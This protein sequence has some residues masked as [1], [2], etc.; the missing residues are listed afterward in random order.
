MN[1]ILTTA[2]ALVLAL[3]LAACE[4][5]APE[6]TTPPESTETAP[7]EPEKGDA[8]ACSE[9]Y[10]E[11][12]RQASKGNDWDDYTY[13]MNIAVD[14]NYGEPTDPRLVAAIQ[15]MLDNREGEENVDEWIM[16][17]GE[18]SLACEELGFA[19]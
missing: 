9:F 3:V 10:D 2:T 11:V 19:P 1:K 7:V 18:T 15:G 12:T 8:V 4:A 5:P 16:Y 6:P 13:R 14:A 17:F